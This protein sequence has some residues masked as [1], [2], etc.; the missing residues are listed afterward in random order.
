MLL[1]FTCQGDLSGESQPAAPSVSQASVF[2]KD[3]IYL[4]EYQELPQYRQHH[5]TQAF[6]I[7]ATQLPG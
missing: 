7:P 4:N 3:L 6:K 1:G 5:Q 2:V